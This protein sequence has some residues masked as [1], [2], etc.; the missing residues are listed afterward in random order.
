MICQ[1]PHPH[2]YLETDF[3]APGKVF[4]GQAMKILKEFDPLLRKFVASGAVEERLTLVWVCPDLLPGVVLVIRKH[5][6]RGFCEGGLREHQRN[7]T[8]ELMSSFH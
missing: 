7:S 2:P 5:E 3:E 8:G 1:R 6:G 4:A